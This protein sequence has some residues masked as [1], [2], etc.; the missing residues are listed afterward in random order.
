MA[1]G[2][3]FSGFFTNS[4]SA[5]EALSRISDRCAVGGFRSCATGAPVECLGSRWEVLQAQIAEN[6]TRDAANEACTNVLSTELLDLCAA[7]S[8]GVSQARASADSCQM[9]KYGCKAAVKPHSFVM[10]DAQL[11]FSSC[12]RFTRQLTT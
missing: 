6:K 8:V 3:A 2:I 1:D 10:S 9:R 4:S 5:T 12:L 7:L 11:T